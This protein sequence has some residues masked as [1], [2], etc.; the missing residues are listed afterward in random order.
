MEECPFEVSGHE[1]KVRSINTV[2]FLGG[3]GSL[4]VSC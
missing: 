4:G 1:L 2:V 3:Q